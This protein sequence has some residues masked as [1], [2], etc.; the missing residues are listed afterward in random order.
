M[1]IG[2]IRC[3]HT[4][5]ICPGTKCLDFARNGLEAFEES[6]PAKVVGFIS[7]GGC[8]GKKAIARAIQLEKRGAE[9]IFF[10]SCATRGIP[11]DYPCPHWENIQSILKKK[12]KENT[13][14]VGWTH[15]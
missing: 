8:P 10:A 14:V 3:Q 15:E 1:K 4:E 5:D 6:G 9:M 12:L 11:W 7:C 2:I 13:R